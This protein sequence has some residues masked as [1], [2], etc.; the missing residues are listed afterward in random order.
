MLFLLLR[1]VIIVAATVAATAAATAAAATPAAAVAAAAA[2]AAVVAAIVSFILHFRCY[3]CSLVV[4]VACADA[5]RCQLPL[6]SALL[7][8]VAA[9]HEF[10][11]WD[12]LKYS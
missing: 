9:E 12:S 6:L 10:Q 2:A 1:F 11:A 5:C 4:F 3:C 7:P 8:L